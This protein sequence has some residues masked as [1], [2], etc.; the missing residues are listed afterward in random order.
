MTTLLSDG[1]GGFDGSVSGNVFAMGVSVGIG[2]GVNDSGVM[3]GNMMPA[4]QPRQIESPELNTMLKFHGELQ[5]DYRTRRSIRHV[6][7]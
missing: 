5:D 7:A 6:I 4:M 1:G 3:V 2:N